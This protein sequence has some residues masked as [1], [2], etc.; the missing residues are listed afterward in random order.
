MLCHNIIINDDKDGEPPALYLL[1]AL[2]HEK[3]HHHPPRQFSHAL[4]VL[5]SS[6]AV[7]QR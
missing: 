7:L 2:A 6:V 5:V 3:L 4:F 1:M